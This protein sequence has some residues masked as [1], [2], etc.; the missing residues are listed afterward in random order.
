[1]GLVHRQS[2][3]IADILPAAFEELDTRQLAERVM[4]QRKPEV[5]Y[6]P[7]RNSVVS[8]VAQSLR[9]AK[10]RRFVHHGREADGYFSLA[11]GLTRNGADR[12]PASTYAAAIRQY[13]H[14]AQR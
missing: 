6:T 7:L 2:R 9:Y 12:L 1:M 8:K 3:L 4:C 11:G 13:P 5:S 14:P 10:R